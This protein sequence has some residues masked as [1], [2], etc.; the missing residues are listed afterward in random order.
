MFRRVLGAGDCI[1]RMV[2]ARPGLR[3]KPAT[4]RVMVLDEVVRSGGVAE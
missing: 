3:S 2:A 4:K 1:V